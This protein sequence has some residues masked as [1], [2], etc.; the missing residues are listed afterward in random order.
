[1]E[2]II[3]DTTALLI[4]DVQNDFLEGGAL[5]VPQGNEVIPYINSI[6]S[7][8][9]HVIATMDW[10]SQDHMSFASNHPGHN[11]G[12]CITIDAISQ[13]LWPDHCVQGTQGAELSEELDKDKIGEII[14]KGLHAECYSAF[15]DCFM[16]KTN[17]LDVLQAR[18][19]DTL[20]VCGLATDYCVKQTA[21]DAALEKYKVY[22]LT[23]G[24]RA[25]NLRPTDGSDA[26]EFMRERGIIIL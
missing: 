24:I 10:H 1:M 16:Q 9:P 5:A 4:V 20:H 6:I 8:Y 23:E 26:I 18:H 13:M 14:K 7:E 21:C 3:T 2:R 11:V 25:V 17:L 19:I 15:Y 12:D 22:L